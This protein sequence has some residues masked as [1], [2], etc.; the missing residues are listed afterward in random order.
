MLLVFGN[1]GDKMSMAMKSDISLFWIGW[2]GA[3]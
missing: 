3:W 1:L 2:V